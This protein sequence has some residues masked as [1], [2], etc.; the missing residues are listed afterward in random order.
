MKNKIMSLRGRSCSLPE[1]I[2]KLHGVAHRTGARRKCRREKR[3]PR[4]DML[5]PNLRGLKDL[6][7]FCFFR[8]KITKSLE[9]E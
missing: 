2:S 7:G 3:P 6:G 4:N 5:I 8:C 9:T 1:A